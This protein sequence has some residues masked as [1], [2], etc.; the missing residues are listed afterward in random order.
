MRV[1][2]IMSLLVSFVF[3]NE[4]EIKSDYESNVIGSYCVMSMNDYTIVDS[5]KSEHTQSV[6][7]ISKIM[8]A[9]VAIE[10]GNLKDK[11][12]VDDI[13]D[14]VDGSMLYLQKGD[15]YTLED[16][17]YGLMLRSGNDAA[18]LIAQHV[19]GSVEDFVRMMND[20][21]KKLKMLSST[22]HNPSG[23]DEE[24]GGNISSSCDI[25]VLMSYAMKNASFA[26][27]VATP[28]YSPCKGKLWV[29]KNKFL[30]EYENATGGKTGYTKQAKRTLVTTS[31]KDGMGIVSVTLNAS[32]DFN[33]HKQMHDSAYEKFEC[34]KLIDKGNYK[35]QNHLYK[36]EN[37][38]YQTIRKGEVDKVK[39]DIERNKKR[40]D[41]KVKYDDITKEYTYE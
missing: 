27:I 6:A 9:I 21:A 3:N 34:V 16:L 33:I 25:A 13:I 8:T 15:T 31:E 19:G 24:D 5:Y 17:L 30:K 18:V 36:I 23:L 7:S 37:D 20:K 10:E 1:F 26:K 29:N 28:S 32:D 4:T 22:F 2:L 12:I 39:L 35:I 14:Q 38:I 40:L 41:I 11:I